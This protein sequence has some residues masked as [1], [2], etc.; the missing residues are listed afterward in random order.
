VS[1]TA[2]FEISRPA[3]GAVG[4]AKQPDRASSG[5]VDSARRSGHTENWLLVLCAANLACAL[6]L[7]Q[8]QPEHL[9]AW[10]ASG[11][12]LPLAVVA[13]LLTPSLARA[14]KS[15]RLSLDRTMIGVG[16]LILLPLLM[17]LGEG[18]GLIDIAGVR[19]VIGVLLGGGFVLVGNYM[20]E[21]IL[22]LFRRY[23]LRQQLARKHPGRHHVDAASADRLLRFVGVG[24]MIAGGLYGFA[25]LL[26]PLA[27]AN[28]W[29]CA[30]F[31][32]VSL[33]VGCRFMLLVNQRNR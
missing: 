31:G 3:V 14:P 15:L 33:F 13:L 10:F 24:F 7:S 27:V 4:R 5:A 21:R 18:L 20:P 12:F 26:A 28:L 8:S 17:R 30:L 1:D 22:P 16:V 9:W 29:A 25:W 32:G 2:Q 19:R 11:L 23:L 6:V